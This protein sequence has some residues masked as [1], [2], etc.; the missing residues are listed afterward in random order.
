MDSFPLHSIYL[1]LTNRCNLFCKHCWLAS[2]PGPKE[3]EEG[4]I[5]LRLLKQAIEDAI[6]LGLE[7]VKIT[8]GEPFLEGC[9]F[10]LI[11]FLHKRG[12]SI[13][14]E[15]NGTLI[16]RECAAFLREKGVSLVCISLDGGRSETHDSLRGREGSFK[17]ALR[18]IRYLLQYGVRVQVIT[19]LHRANDSEIDI[20]LEIL[21]GLDI[22]SLSINPLIPSG[23]G[24]ELVEKGLSLS[25]EE[26]LAIDR[27]IERIRDGYPF[28][29]Y[30]SLPLAFKSMES[31][32]NGR[33]CECNILTILGVLGNGDVSICGVGY[34]E[35]P[36]VFGSLYREG[37]EEIWVNSPFLKSFRKELLEG[38]K[39]VCGRCIFKEL[40]LGYCRANAYT[41]EG[42]IMAPY[43]LCQEA[44]EKG[45]FPETRLLEG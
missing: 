35:R 40:C 10:A 22:D 6:P 32:R 21:K 39:G 15:T 30:F 34:I 27:R 7:H 24:K 19:T 13:T 11:D 4:K 41:M 38:L 28:E 26:L 14:I 23:R 33:L 3:K 29:I 16:T 20:L 37:I 18:A 25:L 31:I 43:W 36:L 12:L 17:E 44:Y 5:D 9:I 8:G 42:D 45:L 1:N 2:G